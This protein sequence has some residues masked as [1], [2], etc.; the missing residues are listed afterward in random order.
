MLVTPRYML[1]LHVRYR[2]IKSYSQRKSRS[3]P[4]IKANN[5]VFGHQQGVHIGRILSKKF[6]FISCKR[7]RK[8][9]LFSYQPRKMAHETEEKNRLK[10]QQ[11]PIT[12]ANQ[13]FVNLSPSCI[14]KFKSA[15]FTQFPLDHSSVQQAS[16]T[17]IMSY[18]HMK[19]CNFL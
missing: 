18:S 3:Q 19:S 2:Y 11:T 15:R 12:S 14:P 5:V 4:W 1:S 10:I 8:R 16:G 17:D 13:F 6:F 9:K 7:K